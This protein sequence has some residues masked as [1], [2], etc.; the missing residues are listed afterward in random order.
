MT[1]DEIWQDLSKYLLKCIFFVEE[2][3]NRVEVW[4]DMSQ[5]K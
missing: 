1:A 5:S 4:K 3:N 2:K